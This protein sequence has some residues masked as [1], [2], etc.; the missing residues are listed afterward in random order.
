MT[1]DL[2]CGGCGR[3]MPAPTVAEEYVVAYVEN[4]GL[5]CPDCDGDLEVAG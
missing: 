5:R 4:G 1:T 2:S 3:V